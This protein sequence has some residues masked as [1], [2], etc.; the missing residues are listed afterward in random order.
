MS[1][2]KL[3]EKL[4]KELGEAKLKDIDI[5]EIDRKER[6]RIK[7]RLWKGEK[8]NGV[9]IYNHPNQ[10]LQ[11]QIREVVDGG[12]EIYLVVQDGKV[13]IMQYHEPEIEG[14]IKMNKDKA[15]KKMKEHG[16]RVVK[17]NTEKEV[18]IKV[19]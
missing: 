16:D 1:R 14:L 3:R 18:R 4:E 12:G 13:V 9:D 11:K 10:M 5:E 6:L 2:G 8:I 17:K 7:T 15:E 19:G